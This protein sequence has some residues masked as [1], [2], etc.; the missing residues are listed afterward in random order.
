M[1]I[2]G[3]SSIA[4]KS[5]KK[6]DLYLRCYACDSLGSEK[7]VFKKD[8]PTYFGFVL[9][10]TSKHPIAYRKLYDPNSKYFSVSV[11]IYKPNEFLGEVNSH[12][13]SD[14][15]GYVLQPNEHLTEIRK[16]PSTYINT[17]VG[18]C[19]A[20]LSFSFDFGEEYCEYFTYKASSVRF[21]RLGD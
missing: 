5:I 3:C 18:S 10:N 1:G 4:T 15:K 16:Y 20:V 8:E 7:K 13:Q 2:L 6:Q 14:W 17:L 12:P 9:K 19:I 21:E 11:A